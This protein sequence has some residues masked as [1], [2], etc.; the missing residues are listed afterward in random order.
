MRTPPVSPAAVILVQQ[1]PC[2][3]KGLLALV[4]NV[5]FHRVEGGLDGTQAV[6]QIH[7]AVDGE[8]QSAVPHRE[9]HPHPVAV[10][11]ALG[12]NRHG[13]FPGGELPEHQGEGLPA[14][15]WASVSS[16]SL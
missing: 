14:G 12:G 11:T 5:D 1:A 8:D 4:V 3:H 16:G 2:L 9:G 13:V 7:N 15:A 10:F 6:R